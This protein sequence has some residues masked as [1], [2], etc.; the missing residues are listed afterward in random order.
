MSQVVK[1]LGDHNPFASDSEGGVTVESD[2]EGDSPEGTNGLPGV[3]GGEEASS[4]AVLTVGSLS[5][6]VYSRLPI[7]SLA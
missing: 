7:P 5:A 3:E 6:Y 2:C 1:C 4:R